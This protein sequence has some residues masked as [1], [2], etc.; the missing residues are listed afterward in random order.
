MKF[1][2]VRNYDEYQPQVWIDDGNYPY[3]QN[4]GE[5]KC[6]FIESAEEVCHRYKRMM[7]NPVVKE[8]EL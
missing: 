3:W 6:E 2:I 7:E 5:Y 4:I 8:F 1:R